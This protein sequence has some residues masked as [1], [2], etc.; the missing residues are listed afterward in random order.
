MKRSSLYFLI[1]DFIIVFLI[2]F[3]P[4]FIDNTHIVA[5][6]ANLTIYI[7]SKVICGL[8]L[9]GSL[10]YLLVKK[11][12]DGVASTIMFSTIITQL[13][14]LFVR[15]IIDN[16]AAQKDVILYS[17]L[18]LGI[19]FFVFV[20]FS[21]AMIIMNKKMVKSDETSEGNTIP[22]V[23]NHKLFDENNKFK[24]DK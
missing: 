15:L 5:S 18:L 17:G 1:S 11:Q 9:L 4:F 21:G 3:I 12:A 22:V 14:P 20:I 19:Y 6:N 16:V 8:L 10:V 24:K 23:D 7:V 13:I 2:I